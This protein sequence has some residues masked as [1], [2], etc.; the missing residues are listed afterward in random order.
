M[1]PSF[2]TSGLRGVVSDLTPACINAYVRGFLHCC[3]WEGPLYLGRDLRPSSAQIAAVVAETARGAGRQ[4]VDCG[5]L[6]TPALAWAASKATAGAIMVTGSH[7]PAD[8]NG[9]KFYGPHGEITKPQETAITQRVRTQ[10]QS[11]QMHPAPM[12]TAAQGNS[13]AC[14]CY[15]Q[16]YITG[17]GV[18]RLAGMRIGVYH[19]SSVASDGLARVLCALGAKVVELDRQATFTPL[20]T[21]ALAPDLCRQLARHVAT[22]K[23]DALVSTDGDGDRP[24]LVDGQGGIVAGDLLG[25]ITAQ[26]VGA[27]DICTPVNCNDLLR[28]HTGGRRVHLTRIGSPFVLAQMARV[29][30]ATAPQQRPVEAGL[31]MD[32]GDPPR[33]IGFEA[34][35]GFILGFQ[36]SGK[37]NISPLWTRDAYLPLLCVLAEAWGPGKTVAQLVADLG[38]AAKRSDRLA[39]IDRAGAGA[40]L[41]A[42][43][44]D[45]QYRAR[46]FH[47]EGR[48]VGIEETDGLRCDFANGL[49][50]HLRL[51]GNAPELRLYIQGPHIS[52][53]DQ[54]MNALK[55]RLSTELAGRAGAAAGSA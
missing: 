45:P 15:L 24:L 52:V 8:R 22:H 37:I 43:C 7:I 53:V 34:N 13:D 6:P 46:F 21:E 50:V 47:P 42:L 25:W 29:S 17:F 28:H 36:I 12:T 4:V 55:I 3:A 39:E 33:V 2:G 54:A 5:A 48:L 41:S 10:S 14:A 40:V 49:S 51:S 31:H 19:H 11:A 26:A 9:L 16:R 35:G 38:A 27:T 20:D 32:R 18:G 23:L 44:N 1:A 30:S